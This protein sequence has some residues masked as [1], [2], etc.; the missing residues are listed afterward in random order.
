MKKLLVVLFGVL[1]IQG[2]VMAR[3]DASRLKDEP[4][5]IAKLTA[6]NDAIF[7]FSE[8]VTETK[9]SLTESEVQA[10]VES[11]V[12]KKSV[13][14]IPLQKLI[15]SKKDDEKLSK[16]ASVCDLCE[17]QNDVLK[18]HSFKPTLESPVTISLAP[19]EGL[20]PDHYKRTRDIDVSWSGF[21]E[22]PDELKISIQLRRVGETGNLLQTDY[23]AEPEDNNI[24]LKKK[25]IKLAISGQKA[26]G[27]QRYVISICTSNTKNCN[28]VDSFLAD[29]EELFFCQ[30]A[31]CEPKTIKDECDEDQACITDKLLKEVAILK[32]KV[33]KMRTNA[34]YA[35]KKMDTKTLKAEFNAKDAAL[36][37][38]INALLAFE[39]AKT[40]N[41]VAV[42][43]GQDSLNSCINDSNSYDS[44][45]WC[46]QGSVKDKKN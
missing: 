22:Q 44:F 29:S 24:L 46:L 31:A 26:D 14:I 7:K 32:R 25:D 41:V 10:E 36:I 13:A 35:Y 3:F 45:K 15:E 39:E 30:G 28:T 42:L 6:L 11:L 8:E 23:S 9:S 38:L 27:K 34:H 43:F 33:K 2:S 17:T 18:K 5:F 37:Q 40:N 4:L 21:G 19:A 1:L 20:K 12:D 16:T